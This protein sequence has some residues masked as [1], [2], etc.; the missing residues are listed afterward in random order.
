M[1]LV[2]YHIVASASPSCY[3]THVVSPFQIADEGDFRPLCTM[4]GSH[5]RNIFSPN[6]S[7]VVFLLQQKTN[8]T[9]F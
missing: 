9:I 7:F 6:Y 8:L 4:E 5:C 2:I 3:E 1:G